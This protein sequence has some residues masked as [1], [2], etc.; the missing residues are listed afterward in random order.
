MDIVRPSV[1]RLPVKNLVILTAAGLVVLVAAVIFTRM[2]PAAAPVEKA[3]VVIDTVRRGAMTRE[4][5]GTGTL[6]P[7]TIR[8]IS[9]ATEARVERVTAQAGTIVTADTV[10]MELSDPQQQ[11]AARDAEWQLRAAEAE[12]LSTQAQ[13]ET[14][15]LDRESAAAE[16]NAEAEQA[17][18]RAAADAELQRNGLVANITRQLSQTTADQYKRRVQLADERL[19]ATHASQGARLAGLRAQVEQRR[20][21]YDLRR[22]QTAALTVR[23]GIDGVLQQVTAQ[24]GQRVSAGANLAR[25]A[26]P[27]KLKAE[28]RIAETQAKDIAVGQHA[29]IDTRNGIVD[30]VVARVDPAVREGTVTVDLRIDAPLP[31]G[32]R[33]DLSV[34]ATVQL[35]RIAD[36]V[37]VSRP[38]GTAEGAAGSV[39]RL[40][41][42]GA[43]AEKVNVQFGRA[44]ATTIEIRSG[45][46]PGD[47]VIVS[48][49]SPFDRNDRI[50]LK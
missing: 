18:L 44:S 29:K 50:E 42:A 25:V 43:A 11:Q 17:R 41:D 40:V 15:R 23:A 6:V 9:A 12:L 28:I 48:D 5:R 3:S 24:A 27:D 26:Q 33:P 8:W 1:R 7:E 20:A 45:L 30:A 16:L 13:L 38:V 32:A 49:S 10:I 47:Q 21:L 19:R 22:Q 4:V 2:R 34:D 14:E 46:Q 36:A 39:F 31:A 37:Y 35:D